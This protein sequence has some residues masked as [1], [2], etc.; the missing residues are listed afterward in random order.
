MK[1]YFYKKRNIDGFNKISFT[2]AIEEGEKEDDLHLN[3]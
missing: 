2:Q 1:F 3:D